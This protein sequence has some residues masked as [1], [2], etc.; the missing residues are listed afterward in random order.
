MRL[1]AGIMPND[2]GYRAQSL[3][4]GRSSEI[5]FQRLGDIFKLIPSD[6]S[7]TPMS[8]LKPYQKPEAIPIEGCR[9]RRIRAPMRGPCSVTRKLCSR[10]PP[11][12]IG[13]SRVL[14]SSP[15]SAYKRPP[16]LR[17]TFPEDAQGGICDLLQ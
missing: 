2:R 17:I 3:S 8:R 16:W 9:S 15:Q 14:F 12:K 13:K 1:A 5:R 4:S 10:L 7:D 11:P 6:G